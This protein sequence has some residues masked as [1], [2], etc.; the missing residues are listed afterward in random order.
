MESRLDYTTGRFGCIADLLARFHVFPE[1]A[2]PEPERS[3]LGFEPVDAVVLALGPIWAER[4]PASFDLDDLM[5]VFRRP[6]PDI[7]LVV[8]LLH[9]DKH[10]AEKQYD[11]NNHQG[12]NASRRIHQ[13]TL[14][15]SGG[16]MMENRC[17]SSVTAS[18]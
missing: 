10:N 9:W 7:L 1:Q 13:T 16:T 12:R 2:P 5:M 17:S 6:R 11:D 4:P 15:S 8:R 14:Y 18:I 3:V